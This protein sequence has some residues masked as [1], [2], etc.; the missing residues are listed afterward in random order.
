MTARFAIDN[1]KAARV[2]LRADLEAACVAELQADVLLRHKILDD[3]KNKATRAR[4]ELAVLAGKCARA[5]MILHGAGA[6][7]PFANA[8]GLATDKLEKIETCEF[9]AQFLKAFGEA[10]R[11]PSI[12]RRQRQAEQFIN[13]FDRNISVVQTKAADVEAHA[14]AEKLLTCGEAPSAVLDLPVIVRQ[15]KQAR[16]E[17]PA[18]ERELSK[19]ETAA[20]KPPGLEDDP[21]GAKT[22]VIGAAIAA[23][24]NLQQA[25]RKAKGLEQT[26]FISIMAKAD[27]AGEADPLTFAEKRFA[28]LTK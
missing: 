24:Q 9:G 13:K 1:L 28:E 3:L 16:K 2:E 6:A 21:V 27:A 4:R 20:A 5:A 11:F 19:A 23:R 26:L 17:I 15:L 18:L 8:A 7:L 22:N 14:R 12:A 10:K 25:T